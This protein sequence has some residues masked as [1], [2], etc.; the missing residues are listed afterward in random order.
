MSVRVKVKVGNLDEYLNL[1]AIA[2][3]GL[4]IFPDSMIHFDV[5]REKSINAINAAMALDRMI[6]LVP[7]VD[8]DVEDPAKADVYDVGVVAEVKQV[9]KMQQ[10][11]IVK[12]MVEAKYRAKTVDIDES[13]K[14]ISAIVTE[15]PVHKIRSGRENVAEALVRS[16]KQAFEIFITVAPKMSKEV[17]S[18]IFMED[19]A[20]K[21]CEFIAANV[22]FKIE[23][24]MSV[25]AENSLEKRLNYVL[26]FLSNEYQVLSIEADIKSKVHAEMEKNQKEYYLRQQMKTISEELDEG[27]D[28]RKESDEYR[29]RISALNLPAEKREKLFKEVNRLEKMMGSS[30]EAAVIRTYLDTC[31]SLPWNIF[32]KEQRNVIKAEKILEKGHYGL[33]KVKEKVLEILSVRQLKE[34]IKGQ[35]ICLVGPPGVGKTSIASSIAE[36]LNRNFVRVSLGGVR[37]ES[38]I[39][40]HRRTYVGAMPGKI[41]NSM[42]SAKSNNPVILLDEIDKLA[43]DFRGDPAAA[44]LEVLDSEQNYAFNDHYIDMPFDL[45]NVFFIATANNMSNIPAPLR[46]RMDIIELSSYTREEKFNIAK[47]HLIP[48]QLDKNGMKPYVKFNDAGIYEI[49][50]CYT[51]E[52]GVRTLERTIVDILRKSAKIIATKQ[53][54]KVTINKKKVVEL[55]GAEKFKPNNLELKDTIGLANGLAWTSVGGEMLP[56]EVTVIPKGAGRLEL[57]GSLGDV[58]KESCKIALSYIK[59]NAE[60]YGIDTDFSKIDIHIHA[61]E[62]AVPK[63]G[64]SAGITLTTALLSVL[65]NRSVK[66]DVAMT[67]EVTLQGR[68][69]PIGGL[70]EKAMAA[71]REGIKTVIIP[72]DNQPNLEDVDKVV[73]EQVKFVP[74]KTID[75]AISVNLN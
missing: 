35:I 73:K 61:P 74:V 7:Q 56:I 6:Y 24:K 25:L 50:D 14:Y 62:G 66:G 65:T 31:L 42:I 55:L 30:Q 53:A 29:D 17:I 9:L 10:D 69:L 51:K 47:K 15:Y 5:G 49:I 70:K 75:Q 41:I 13:G 22:M 45:S 67:G 2:L 36:C 46:D 38:E 63:D 64:P 23:D 37:D 3:R 19:D 71:Y 48:K 57:T 52:A 28:T 34:D 20:N 11:G 26:K 33:E 1:P 18:K 27:E 60:R 40:G 68:V 16:V 54:E 12:V 39:R 43:G 44:L 21:L 72:F 59:A 4:V 8:I 32:T 58:M